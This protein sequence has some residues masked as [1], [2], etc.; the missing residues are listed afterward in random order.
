VVAPADA[1]DTTIGA[2]GDEDRPEFVFR[3]SDYW[4][5]GLSIGITKEF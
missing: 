4:V 1:I 3:H 2:A 5:Q